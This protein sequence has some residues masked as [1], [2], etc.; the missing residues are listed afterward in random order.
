MKLK[1]YLRG[2]GIGMIATTIILM[3]CFSQQDTTVSDE[4]VIERA[5][6]LGMVMPEDT[7]AQDSTEPTEGMAEN[8][9]QNTEKQDGFV[10]GHSNTP[11]TMAGNNRQDISDD[12]NSMGRDPEN[13]Q[14]HTEV[15]A[16]ED[17]EAKT[18]ESIQKDTERKA[19]GNSPDAS[20]TQEPADASK[21]AGEKAPTS[22]QP[23]KS[24]NYRL[25]IKKGDVCR[26]ICDTLQA[27]GLIEDSES[28][29][30]HLSGIGRASTLATG[31]YEIP[32]GITME[33]VAELLA[34]GP[35]ERMD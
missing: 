24:G 29:R 13:V 25:I 32:Y 5:K 6:A 14:N 17:T 1:Y 27:N 20:E 10:T 28:L 9:N 12:N 16:P 31:A 4:Y 35:V 3:I 34:E 33:E 18:P 7:E 15:K 30:K 8:D 21:N 19:E 2:L 23:A 11:V 22:D 26:T